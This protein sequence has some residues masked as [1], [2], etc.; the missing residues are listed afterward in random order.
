LWNSS[1]FFKGNWQIISLL[2]T[3]KSSSLEFDNSFSLASLIGPAV[4][5][6][7]FS[8]EAVTLIENY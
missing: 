2:K 5:K 1:N 4:P 7:S 3:K 8:I 6:G